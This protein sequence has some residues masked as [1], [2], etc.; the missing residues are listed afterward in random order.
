MRPGH[1]GAGMIALWLMLTP[2]GSG[3]CPDC[4]YDFTAQFVHGTSNG[5]RVVNVCLT[6]APVGP[7][8]IVAAGFTNAVTSGN[9]KWNSTSVPYAFQLTSPASNCAAADIKVTT[10][11]T[12]PQAGA[13]INLASYPYTLTIDSSI[14]VASWGPILAHEYGHYMGLADVSPANG[15]STGRI[16]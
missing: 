6:G 3:A 10:G 11:S 12:M 7:G 2:L 14:P 8:G 9:N 4:Y 1:C 13:N 5:K 15:C 16:A